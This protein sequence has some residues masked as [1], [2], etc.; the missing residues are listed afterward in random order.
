MGK[1]DLG[2]GASASALGSRV[3]L[4]CAL[5]LTVIFVLLFVRT[6]AAVPRGL[7]L[8]DESLA[9]LSYRY[10]SNPD[11]LHT[12]AGA[13]FGPIFRLVGWSV[14]RLR[15]VKL[16]LLLSSGWILGSSVVRWA[17][18]NLA[19]IDPIEG[20]CLKVLISLGGFTAYTW[21][22]QT[23]SYNDL[24]AMTVT[25]SAAG[26]LS[27]SGGT[28]RSRAWLVT[29]GAVM[30]ISTLNKWPTA[31]ATGIVIGVHLL[32]SP[33]LR[34]FGRRRAV[35]LF[36]YGVAACT[37]VLYVVGSFP[38][39]YVVAVSQVAQSNGGDGRLIDTYLIPYWETVRNV[40]TTILRQYGL[41]LLA[42]IVTAAAAGRIRSRRLTDAMWVACGVGYIL[43]LALGFRH[44][45]FATGSDSLGSIERSLALLFVAGAATMAV[46]GIYRCVGS[47]ASDRS[48]SPVVTAS[49]TLIGLWLAP[50]AGTDNS[51][52]AVAHVS[53]SVAFAFVAVALI[54]AATCDR[55][56]VVAALPL[57]VMCTVLA[58]S[59][60][61]GGL[62][63]Q[64]YRLQG[65][66]SEQST[67][68]RGV[69]LLN[70]LSVD[71]GTAQL[72]SRL[73]TLSRHEDLAGLSGFS[74]FATP[75]LA[76][77]L[78]LK[79]PLAGL[80]VRA[81]GYVGYQPLYDDRLRLA[82]K[83]GLI[84][85]TRSPVVIALGEEPTPAI[86]PLLEA[87]G[88]EM[89]DY[90]ALAIESPGLPMVPEGKITVWV[91]LSVSEGL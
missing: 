47:V 48:F 19:P 45:L 61:V 50:A 41:T 67:P 43:V 18:W 1:L 21:T 24:A 64:P 69:P 22:P 59:A 9:I 77:A 89:V 28:A 60:V 87:C 85:R 54:Y 72:L 42:V 4:V 80:W 32:F 35:L 25:V 30:A 75:G 10:Y 6:V 15:L 79:Q 5:G 78:G 14:P 56:S 82:C 38:H 68:I 8:S 86:G 63:R 58:I 34:E 81:P 53:G 26:L 13:F 31:F 65:T 91:P 23:P 40:T 46:G 12:G 11:L 66:L 70:G 57:V 2:S 71:P 37:V 88:V 76:I 73:S 36:C 3:R 44:R 33:Y 55:R 7:D 62:W 52:L 20:Y 27:L 74:S 16:V 51:I 84:S 90:R 29:L 83:N 49:L 39:R 17:R